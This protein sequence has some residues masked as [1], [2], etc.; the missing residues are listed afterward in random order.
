MFMSC[1]VLD[2]CVFIYF[3]KLRDYLL[4]FT[5]T[6]TNVCAENLYTEAQLRE[7]PL[8]DRKAP[9]DLKLENVG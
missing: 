2:V 6:N 8:A 4:V 9:R 5:F 1:F 3:F 7:I